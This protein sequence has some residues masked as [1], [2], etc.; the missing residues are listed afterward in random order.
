M[1]LLAILSCRNESITNKNDTSYRDLKDVLKSKKLVALVDNSS[2]SYFLYK[3]CPMGFEYELLN[4]FTS[5]LG[6]EL[7]IVVCKNMD[8][9]F[10]YI[11]NGKA[12]I[13][14]A[15]LTV[16]ES[17]KRIV[18]F[19]EPILNTHQVLIQRKPNNWRN[20]STSFIEDFLVRS[21]L[22]LKNKE[23]YVRKNS[24][25]YTRLK[26]LNEEIG[27]G[28]IIKEVDGMTSTEMLIEQVAN[29]DISYTVA[30]Y[31]VALVNNRFYN[32]IDIQTP[33]SVTQEIGWCLNKNS[34][35]LLNEL[36]N[37]IKQFKKTKK[38]KL[39]KNKYF[40]NRQK[41][42][43]NKDDLY[44]NFSGAISPYDA[45]IKKHAAIIG[46]DWKLI[47]SLIYQESRFNL[48]A[49]SWSG[50]FGL[51]QFMPQTAAKYGIDSTSSAEL[52]IKAG[53][54]YL[55]R[56]DDIWKPHI[57]NP[58]ERAKFVLASYNVGPGHIIDA[59]KLAK[60]YGKKDT[61][62]EQEVDSFVL[63][64]SEPEYYKDPVVKHG[65]CRGYETFKFVEEILIRYEHYKNITEKD[66][67]LTS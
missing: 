23:V 50:A 22:E 4:E 61:I 51:M 31:N 52:Q 46:W 56:L 13:A 33:L 11:K 35:Q 60:K 54:K 43:S 44:L 47:A 14:A 45:L 26:H 12:D 53:I 62:W 30:D 37:W 40:N 42:L 6:I 7:D 41:A 48:K 10:S 25:F 66:N 28:I 5:Y 17:R 67:T 63:R 3:G 34:K 39:L 36:N 19:T 20:Y 21:P 29:G 9:I 24:S 65:Y 55:K 58:N 18:T 38:F 15:N 32:N 64:K 57:K 8:S 49:K 2:T 1:T 27:G 16:T 59:K